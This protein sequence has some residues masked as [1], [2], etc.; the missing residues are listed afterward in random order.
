VRASQA[1]FF[2]VAGAWRLVAESRGRSMVTA[3]AL[4]ET[5][6]KAAVADYAEWMGRRDA[7]LTLHEACVTGRR[8]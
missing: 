7:A 5:E 1:D 6:R 3:G 2:R 8:P 4:T